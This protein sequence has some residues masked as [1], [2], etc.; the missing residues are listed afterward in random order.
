MD[1]EIQIEGTT[2]LVKVPVHVNGQ[3]PFAFDM[4]TG[5][6]TTTISNRLAEKLGI[7]IFDDSRDDARGVGG[8]VSTKFA[9]IDQ[10]NIGSLIFANEEVYV[11]DLDSMFRGCGTH[12]G[13]LGHSTIKHCI[14]SLSYQKRR[15]KLQ[16]GNSSPKHEEQEHD[17]K[18]FEYVKDSHLIQ[19]PVMINNRGPFG[20]VIDTGAGSSVITPELAMLLNLKTQPVNGIARGIGGDV[21]LEF[22]SL[23]LFSFDSF[24]KDGMQVAVV[25]LASVSPRG[26]LI[27]YGIIGFDI[28]RH[29][30]LVIDYPRKQLA[31]IPEHNSKAS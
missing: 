26:R 9:N 4:D 29:I 19:I 20:F 5:A 3:G 24:E 2:N 13:V 8:T 30:E 17:W 10:I 1:V 22:A 12:D 6:S 23:D 16:M 18:S 28:L 15:L 31:F 7:Q 25:D 27:E 11:L 14:I 21:K